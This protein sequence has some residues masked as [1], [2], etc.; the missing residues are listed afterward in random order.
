METG[1]GLGMRLAWQ[2]VWCLDLVTYRRLL[3]PVAYYSLHEFYLKSGLDQLQKEYLSI[4][5]LL[6][7][8]EFIIY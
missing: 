5:T 1:Q 8:Y 4:K 6:G 7:R 3:Y 2:L